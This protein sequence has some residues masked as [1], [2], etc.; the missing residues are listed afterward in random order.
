MLR[1]IITD[2]IV[3]KEISFERITYLLGIGLLIT[4]ILG[5]IEF[6]AKNIYFI[7]VD[8]Y[9]PRVAVEG[10]KPFASGFIRIRSVII[11]SGHLAFYY[12][13]LGP[14]GLYGL[15][16]NR[17]LFVLTL[18]TMLFCFIFSFSTAGWVIAGGISAI[19]LI[20]RTIRKLFQ[21]NR[22][23]KIVRAIS[24]ATFSILIVTASFS[25]YKTVG[26]QIIEATV[27]NKVIASGS[28]ND[29]SERA[30]QV[31]ETIN[32]AD[33]LHLIFGYGPAAYDSL[34]YDAA[35][36]VLYFTFLLESGALGLSLFLLFILF[37][38]IDIISIK[39]KT[40][41]TI[42]LCSLVAALV[43]FVSISNYWY[44]WFWVL[45]ILS[46]IAKSKL[47]EAP[48]KETTTL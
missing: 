17:K 20:G 3:K 33:A 35:A 30:V 5:L 13:I 1:N 42:F 37:N 38:F 26:S 48:L 43:H 23:I 16:K 27:Y 34:R 15:R 45:L 6:V 40:L 39:D 8:Q 2:Q 32:N 4:S 7:D 9:I 24:I 29:R 36:L 25:L 44:P 46:Q 21:I 22:K 47:D 18:I 41:R 12:E 11:E 31:V 10:Y 14:I 28:A 19:I